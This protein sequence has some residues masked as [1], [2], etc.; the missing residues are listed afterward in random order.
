M[1][2][3][4]TSAK[5]SLAVCILSAAVLILWL[6]TFPKFFNWFYVI[7]HGL[8]SAN[9]YVNGAVRIVVAV[10]YCCAPFAGGALYCLIRLLL[11]IIGDRV[12][13]I[14]NAKY[15]RYVSWA[16]YGVFVVTAVT[17]IVKYMPLLIIAFSTGIVGTLLR[18]VKNIMQSAVEISEE[19]ELTI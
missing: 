5:I 14:E 10:F 1:L 11:N 16:C 12:F 8:D 3:R 4:K 19:N 7:Y 6:F 17:G 2:N 18:V 15:L 9:N 13:I